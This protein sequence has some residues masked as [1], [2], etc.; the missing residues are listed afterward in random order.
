MCMTVLDLGLCWYRCT[1]LQGAGAGCG[2][3]MSM[4]SCALGLSCRVLL[5]VTMA[6]PLGWTAIEADET[7]N[8]TRGVSDAELCQ[9]LSEGR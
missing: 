9:S 1:V 4:T 8:V 6:A 2:C 7:R 3:E 5:P